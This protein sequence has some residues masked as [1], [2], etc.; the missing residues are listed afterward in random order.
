MKSD[1]V[2]DWLIFGKLFG[3]W[4]VVMVLLWA[5]T[6]SYDLYAPYTLITP[7]F[8]PDSRGYIGPWGGHGKQ[9]EQKG[10]RK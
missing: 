8:N 5:G 1:F 4:V 7:R 2:F 10:K 9:G 3:I 6:T